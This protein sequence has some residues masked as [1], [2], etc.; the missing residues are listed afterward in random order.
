M[1]FLR[2]DFES[3]SCLLPIQSLDSQCIKKM[4]ENTEP[5]SKDSVQPVYMVW[6]QHPISPIIPLSL[7]LWLYSDPM[8]GTQ[9]TDG[10][11][12]CQ[13]ASTPRRT[14]LN[15]WLVGG[16][17][18]DFAERMELWNTET[19]SVPQNAPQRALP[20]VLRCLSSLRISSFANLHS[21]L[22]NT[23]LFEWNSLCFCLNMLASSFMIN[24]LRPS[25]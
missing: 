19:K 13:L 14:G 8:R 23:P 2:T 1:S 17:N 20:N 24:F 15:T 12:P 25:G 9:V 5:G 3:V 4:N 10:C 6:S 11:N 21:H 16:K 7:V 18:C 22:L